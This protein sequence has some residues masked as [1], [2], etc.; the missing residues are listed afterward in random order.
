MGKKHTIF[1][2]FWGFWAPLQNP[3][4]FVK[5]DHFWCFWDPP[6]LVFV[7]PPTESI[8][9]VFSISLFLCL[10]FVCMFLESVFMSLFV[11][12]F[13]ITFLGWGGI[14]YFVPNCL[15][16]WCFLYT[17]IQLQKWILDHIDVVYQIGGV[18]PIWGCTPTCGVGLQSGRDLGGV[19]FWNGWK[20]VYKTTWSETTLFT[21]I[22]VWHYNKW[23]ELQFGTK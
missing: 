11:S 19:E 9:C 3:P 15:S 5:N 10:L 6:F 13:W 17:G 16:L 14:L 2:G 4:T 22:P 7:N 8:F 1:E 18:S 20:C 23:T 21:Y 12:V